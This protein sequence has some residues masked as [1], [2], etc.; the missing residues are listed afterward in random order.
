MDKNII[1]VLNAIGDAIQKKDNEIFVQKCKIK[2]LEN[3]L[4]AA[5]AKVNEL[6][7]QLDGTICPLPTRPEVSE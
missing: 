5:E 7:G 1:T 3:A 4:D 2:R 6:Q